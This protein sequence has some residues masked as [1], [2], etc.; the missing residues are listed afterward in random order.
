MAI[1]LLPLTN[2]ICPNITNGTT[3]V[4]MLPTILDTK[5]TII[6]ALNEK[7]QQR[8]AMIEN[9]AAGTNLIKHAMK[10]ASIIAPINLITT[11]I[12][13]LN[14]VDKETIHQ[15]QQIHANHTHR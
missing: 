11:I 9:A 4:N 7:W 3:N 14:N 1:N 5:D 15:I 10:N 12:F 13:N 2:F 6:N 8:W